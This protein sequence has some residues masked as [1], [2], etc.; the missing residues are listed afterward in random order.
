LAFRLSAGSLQY[1]DPTHGCIFLND[2]TAPKHNSEFF[3]GRS[4]EANMTQKNMH[5]R[6]RG[7]RW[8]RLLLTVLM[9]LFV[10]AGLAVGQADQGAITGTVADSSGARIPN[11][12]SHS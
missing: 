6:L 8:S 7:L 10:S 2:A 9:T 3:N 11:A 4:L 1:H 5:F 12:E